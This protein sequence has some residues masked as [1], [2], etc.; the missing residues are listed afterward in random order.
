V[1]QPI[2]L[3]LLSF[4]IYYAPREPLNLWNDSTALAHR[5]D[6]LC[7]RLLRSVSTRL[8]SSRILCSS[9]VI[10]HAHYNGH[11][12]NNRTA[13]L[14]DARSP[15]L[16]LT[17]RK[18]PYYWVL[19]LTRSPKSEPMRNCAQRR[20]ARDSNNR[21][22]IQQFSW[23]LCRLFPTFTDPSH[24]YLILSGVRSRVLHKSRFG[25]RSSRSLEEIVFS[26]AFRLFGSCKVAINKVRLDGE[27]GGGDTTRVQ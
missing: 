23:I 5:N 25:L 22:L 12:R 14:Q 20:V 6:G 4:I 26:A 17:R 2:L 21:S 3:L 7:S 18:L 24:N 16:P 10:R 27:S 11:S 15:L 19:S 8:G 13:V 1:R 9:R